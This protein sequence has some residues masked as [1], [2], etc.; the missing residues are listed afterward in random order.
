MKFNLIIVISAGMAVA[1][2]FGAASAQQKSQWDGVY[3]IEQAKRGEPLYSQ[4]CAECHGPD[5]S[6][7]EIAPGLNSSDFMANWNDLTLA[8]LFDRMKT[9]MP[10]NNPNSLSRE[11]TADILAFILLKTDFPAGATE[12][13][14]EPA[15]LG[16]I[17]YLATKP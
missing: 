8:Q 6:G 1:G 10:Q 3:T 9:S 17:R 12:L 16:A 7:G 11:Q 5:L 14:T 4:F 13:S 15:A 2:A